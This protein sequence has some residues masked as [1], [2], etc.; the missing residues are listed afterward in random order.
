M[1]IQ[2]HRLLLCLLL[3]TAQQSWAWSSQLGIS[4]DTVMSTATDKCPHHD[5]MDMSAS[6][7]QGAAT[8]QHGCTHDGHCQ[9]AHAGASTAMPTTRPALAGAPPANLSVT[10]SPGV[11]LDAAITPLLRPPARF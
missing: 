2:L 7:D 1:N 10:D 11:T 6:T 4:G 8:A 5:G 3:L 9:C